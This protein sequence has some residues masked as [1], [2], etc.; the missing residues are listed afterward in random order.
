MANEI[1]LTAGLSVVKSG[2]SISGILS[3]L[4]ITQSG[5]NNIGSVQNVGLTSEA[6]SIGDVSTIGYLYVKNL[7]AT[8]FVT[9]D[10]NNPAV[11]SSGYATLKAGEA[12]VVP[13]RRTAHYAIADTGACDLLV[14][15]LEL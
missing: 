10:L 11:A 4:A 14:I 8:N 5:T 9:I 3:A 1:S 2:Q 7:D 15:A 12:M 6:L 13:T